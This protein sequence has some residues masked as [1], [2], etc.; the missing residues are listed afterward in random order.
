MGA[1]KSKLQ[2]KDFN[3]TDLQKVNVNLPAINPKITQLPI[4][5]E[6]EKDLEKFI[7]DSEQKQKEA[8]EQVRSMP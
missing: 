3:G 4:N 8:K 7:L 5:L 1:I 6:D 2:V